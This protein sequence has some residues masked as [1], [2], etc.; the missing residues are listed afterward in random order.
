M[1]VVI[2]GKIHQYCHSINGSTFVLIW[3]NNHACRGNWLLWGFL[4]SQPKARQLVDFLGIVWSLYVICQCCYTGMWQYLALCGVISELYGMSL[5]LQAY[6]VYVLS[7]GCSL[8]WEW[9]QLFQIFR[10]CFLSFLIGLSL[11]QLVFSLL[12]SCHG[13][14][15]D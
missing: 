15:F 10:S 13:F 11:Y 9:Y 12:I 4:I 1:E 2:L 14:L 7:T 3:S 8:L 5:S 6:L